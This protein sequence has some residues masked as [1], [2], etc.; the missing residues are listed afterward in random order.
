MVLKLV[1]VK[2][3]A[4]VG[5]QGCP[6]LLSRPK[7]KKIKSRRSRRFNKELIKS[8]KPKMTGQATA[9]TGSSEGRKMRS[10]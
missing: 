8:V 4:V 9:M 6:R 1:V 7:D 2:T 10:T 3:R 5:L